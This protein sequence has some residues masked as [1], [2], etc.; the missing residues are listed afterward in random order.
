MVLATN[1]ADA[2]SVAM[3]ASERDALRIGAEITG[4]SGG[5]DPFAA[6]VR[7]T[8]MPMIISNPRLP[9]N[10]VVFVNDSFC[11]LTGYAR[12]EIVG[13]NCR[14]LQ[15]P[16]TDPKTVASIRRAVAEE[17]PIE[18]DICN[19]RRGGEPFWNRL[20]MAPV[21]DA[22]G[23]LAYFF[24]SQV[25]VTIERERLAGL[26]T[27]NSSLM[28][29][30]A[31]R[32]RAQQDSEERLRFAAQAGR[33]G[34]WERDIATGALTTSALCREIF[35]R[36]PARDFPYDAL[37]AAI[38]P[39]D[40][41]RVEAAVA[42]S[43][44]AT[45]SYDIE[46]RIIRPDGAT[47]WVQARAKMVRAHDGTPLRLAGV[48]L[49]VTDRREAEE[50]LRRTS[51]LLGTI[52]ETAPGLIYAKDRAG[53]MVIANSA[54][55]A[56]IGKGWQEVEGRND[57]EFLHD[58]AQAEA[59]MENDSR[60][61]R[62]GVV[63]SLEEL[64]GTGSETPRTWL[65]TKAPLRDPDG[66]VTGMVGISMDIS[67]RKQAEAAL[68]RLNATLEARVA[69]RTAERDQAWRNSQDL[70][71]I[72]NASGV[73]TAANP[74]WNT[75]LGWQP[76]EV[77]GRHHLD[78]NH[79]DDRQASAAAHAQ[80]MVEQLPIYESR[81]LHH[82]GSYRWIA[83]VA[84][85]EGGLTYATGRDV[86]A[87]HE[88]AAVLTRTEDLLRQSQKMEAV[89]QLTGGI[90]HDFNNLLTA[91]TGSLELLQKSVRSGRFENLERYTSAAI[92]ASQRAAALTQ[93]L[94]A[95]ARR[96]PL[97]PK[98]VDGNRLVA[99]M[100]ELIRRTLGPGIDM[101]MVLAGGLWPTL[102]DPN[103]LESAIL[104]LA[105]NAR[106][107]MP[108]GGRLTIETSNAHLDDSYVRSQGGELKAGQYVAIAVSDTGTGMPPDVV[109][110]AFDPFFTTK[111]IG[112]GTGLGLSMLYG[113]VKQS[114]GHVRIYS[115]P[116]LGT[117]FRLY[118]PRLRG[119][120]EEVLPEAAIT[121][122]VQGP[123]KGKTVLVV[124]DEPTLRML[125][126][127]TLQSLGYG[128]IEAPDGPAALR[129]LQSDM[130]VDLLVTDVGMPGLNGRQLADAA[131]AAR[132]A[133]RVLFSTGYAHNAAI[134]NGAAL[135]P[136][137]EIMTKPFALDALGAKINEMI[138]AR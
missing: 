82:D 49:D 91:I 45:G 130:A 106:D 85:T 134:G 15:G 39:R 26:E 55:L 18:I 61:M 89:G 32:L 75:V 110:R 23:R 41:A 97:D 137:M 96:Q 68:Q 66:G 86:T 74:A 132:P 28:A 25:D 101:E 112:H 127:E 31:G 107:A 33:M 71:V 54:T 59:V 117:T 48:S 6:A 81:V 19:Y 92:T 46:Y 72:V 12:E 36:D 5:T 21:R 133:L 120:A 125:V 138:E 64:V 62:D 22:A 105:I 24:A 126:S 113:F 38:H 42:G 87:D 129:I 84:A 7:A 40:R 51:A 122:P 16:Q 56:L 27:M 65:S 3:Q 76:D 124:D 53:R 93:R 50:E 109:E 136:G 4:A 80:A 37:L 78:F 73:F 11:Q 9:D 123:A 83:W 94:L 17:R 108:T 69:E 119:S 131:R 2:L 135:A 20:L 67:A 60:V 114:D 95:F 44:D 58:Q 57:R 34:F 13:R 111:P 70:I 35:G 104:N 115:E 99:G 121:E 98:R 63:Q 10:P 118:L 102:C 79:P 47:A 88:A 116:G 103:Q 30:V 14:F 128:A 100:E 29:E 90:A 43:L 8:R 52:I 1:E 77:V